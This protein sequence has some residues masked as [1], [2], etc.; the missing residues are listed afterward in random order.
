MAFIGQGKING[1]SM[2]RFE[3]SKKKYY[4]I[5]EVLQVFGMWNLINKSAFDVRLSKK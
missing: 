2:F 1:L 4:S 5:K 3:R